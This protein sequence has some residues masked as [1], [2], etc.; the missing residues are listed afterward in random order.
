MKIKGIIVEILRKW[1]V[2]SIIQNQ[3]KINW[4]DKRGLEWTIDVQIMGW[5]EFLKIE[6]KIV[7]LKIKDQNKVLAKIGDQN[8][9]TFLFY[10]INL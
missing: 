5:S 7:Q 10:F 4:N 1:G 3:K 2:R 6:I 9:I 8:C